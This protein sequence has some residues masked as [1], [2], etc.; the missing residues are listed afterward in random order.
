M[1]IAIITSGILPFP[2]VQGGAVENLI[3]FYL[4]YNN[5]HK[6]HDITIYS[7]KHPGTKKHPSLKSKVN[8]YI[9]I[10]TNSLWAKIKKWIYLKRNGGEEL[11]HYSIEYFIEQILNNIQKQSYE[12]IIIENR[13]AFALKLKK[14]TTA[15]L[16]YHIHNEK[17][18]NNPQISD[19]ICQAATLIICVSNYIAAYMKQAVPANNKCI[20]VYNGINTAAFSKNSNTFITRE[21]IGLA[22]NDFVLVFSGRITQEKGVSE[23]LDSMLLIKSYTNIKLLIIGSSFYGNAN[24]DTPFINQLKSK[25]EIIKNTIIFTGFVPYQQIPNYLS[26]ADL[27]I[28]P[29]VWD[30]PFPTTVLEAQAMGLPIITT[31]RGGIPEEVTNDNA[32]LLETDGLF[33]ENLANAILDLYHHPEK[34]A[35]MSKASLERSKMFDKETYARNFFE[36]IKDIHP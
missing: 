26:I 33:V 27:A 16:V 23:L 30:D 28:I 13:P 32:V 35:A 3:D 12:L 8:H 17:L 19:E 5:I 4:E 2:A 9:Y 24:N 14:I 22:S 18:P 1:K 10:D 29:S 7:C 34:R 21:S 25:T 15:P 36:A 31:R 11:Y 6:L 20:S